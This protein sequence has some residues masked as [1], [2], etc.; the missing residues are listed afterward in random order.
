M[1]LGRLWVHAL[2]PKVS[3]EHQHHL[4]IGE[5]PA[6]HLEVLED[7][8]VLA[9]LVEGNHLDPV[10]DIDRFVAGVPVVAY[11]FVG[12]RRARIARR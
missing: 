8:F 5:A 9:G 3:F 7:P 11:P 10:D 12:L 1:S 4:L 2:P 6:V